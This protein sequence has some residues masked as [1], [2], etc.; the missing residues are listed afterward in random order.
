MRDP[1][2]NTHYTQDD[3]AWPD[4]AHTPKILFERAQVGR[5]RI[6]ATVKQQLFCVKAD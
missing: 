4:K 6:F 2:P 5:T 3:A 1:N